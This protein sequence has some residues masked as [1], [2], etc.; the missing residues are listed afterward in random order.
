M[1]KS[2]NIILLLILILFTACNDDKKQHQ[3]TNELI[4]ETSPYL[5][6]HAHNPVNWKAW[7]EASLAQAKKENKLIV[8][9]IG[10]AACHWCHVMEKESFEDSL[11]AKKMNLDFI[12]IKVDREERPD[13][14][15]V[16]MKAVQ[17]MSGNGGWPLN[18]IALPDGRPIWGGTYF[19]K[20]QWQKA[21]QQ[22]SE[23]FKKSPEKF[24]AF[25]NKL[26][27]GIK[28]VDLITLNTDKPDFTKVF[29]ADEVKKW[30]NEFD[31]S[32]G[33]TDRNPKFM[34]PNNYQFLMRYAFQNSDKQLMN[35]VQNTLDKMA[36]GGIYDQINGGFSRYSTDK[37]WHIPHFEKMLYDNA[38]LVSLYSKAYQ[39]TKNE[40][41]KNVVFETLEFV[42]KELTAS[43]GVF[44]SSLDADSY[45]TENVLEEGAYYSWTKEELKMILKNDFQL[46][47]K[48][49]NINDY[50]L[51]EHEKYVLIKS[52]NDITFTKENNISI[53]EL[54]SK[55]NVWK[56]SLQQKQR[57]RKKP[58]LDDKSLTSWNALMINGYLDA[59]SIF[60]KK[61]YLKTAEKTAR[62]ILKNQLTKKGKLFH[63]YKKGKVSI[64]GYLEDYASTTK[65]FIQLYQITANETWLEKAELLTQYAITNF[66]D[67]ASKMF[68][69]TSKKD[70]S[71]VAKTIEY[72]DNVIASSNS[73]MAKNL[74]ILS[75]HLDNKS[76]KE[77]A[78]A[79]LNNVKSEITNNA[80]SFSNWLDLMLNYTNPY[81]EVVISG[82]DAETKLTE[83]NSTYIPNI[84]VAYSSNESGLPLLKNRFV[85]NETFIYVCIDN[86]C[87]LPVNTIH[88]TIQL[89]KK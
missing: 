82:K 80:S 45:N 76:Y 21:L 30:S 79:M 22:I 20:K 4:H 72:Q 70:P 57:E 24:Y 55:K 58:R 23:S 63:N 67:D 12:N 52:V 18:V 84:L 1:V 11:I 78:I 61:E 73:I 86:T 2:Y 41:Y 36:F 75:H 64:N 68:Y 71:L 27:E 28:N 48:Y 6:Q 81:Y 19:S 25:A 39:I 15:K 7:N 74:F 51:W 38:Q 34:L 46:F 14:D 37:K 49:Y 89:I 42:E 16:Y 60:N 83:L 62:F 47:S 88:E 35:H 5:L 26:E 85:N 32:F 44:Y 13:V 59:Y 53:S 10:Y 8:I 33:G 29:I 31:N 17:L 3:F 56:K 65:A 77:M 9:S 50:G 54:E 87:K 40:T 66:Y 43:E 69:F